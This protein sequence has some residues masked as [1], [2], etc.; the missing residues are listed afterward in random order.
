MS[1]RIYQTIRAETKRERGE[2]ERERERKRER[3]EEIGGR[4]KETE[5]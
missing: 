1:L 2:R 4:E 5:R 3:Y